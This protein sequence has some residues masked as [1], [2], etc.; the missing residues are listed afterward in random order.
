MRDVR[1]ISSTLPLSKVL[2]AKTIKQ[3]VALCNKIKK[4]RQT[5]MKKR[6]GLNEDLIAVGVNRDDEDV[7]G[8]DE[9]GIDEEPLQEPR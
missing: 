9:E 2:K 1:H 4:E 8:N 3:Y 5:K 6:G 7:T